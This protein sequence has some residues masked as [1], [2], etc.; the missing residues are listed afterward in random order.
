MDLLE[1]VIKRTS[2]FVVYAFASI[3]ADES[4]GSRDLSHAL[5]L[6]K[7]AGSSSVKKYVVPPSKTLFIAEYGTSGRSDAKPLP[8]TLISH[9][10]DEGGR[11]AL[12]RHWYPS[13][14]V[15]FDYTMSEGD[16]LVFFLHKK[17]R[18]EETIPCG[19]SKK[20][21]GILYS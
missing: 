17:G 16:P 15:M 2:S 5:R 9:L 7:S 18:L 6:C 13:V 4:V 12:V 3:D 8:L 11:V 1:G 21:R 14:D 10:N 19:S 20:Q